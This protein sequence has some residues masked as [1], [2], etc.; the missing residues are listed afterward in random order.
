LRAEARALR[1][2]HGLCPHRDDERH[3]PDG[4]AA[5]ADK[6]PAKICALCGRSQLIVKAIAEAFA[7]PLPVQPELITKNLLR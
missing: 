6:A 1:D 2:A 3:Y 4:E 7:K 5:A